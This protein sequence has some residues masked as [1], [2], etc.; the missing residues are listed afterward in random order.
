MPEV[1]SVDPQ[2]EKRTDLA[3]RYLDLDNAPMLEYTRV[4]FGRRQD[5]DV[6]WVPTSA[7][8]HWDRGVLHRVR[9]NGYRLKKDDTIGKIEESDSVKVVD[10]KVQLKLSAPYPIEWLQ[11]IVDLYGAIPKLTKYDPEQGSWASRESAVG[12]HTIIRA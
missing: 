5:I 9:L 4:G 2:G 7:V 8:L 6:R 10:G 12:P 11:S 1:M 3:E